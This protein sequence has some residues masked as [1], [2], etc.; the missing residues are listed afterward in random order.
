MGIEIRKDCKRAVA[1]VKCI[2][3]YHRLSST[4]KCT[5]TD[6]MDVKSDENDESDDQ[7]DSDFNPVTQ[8]YI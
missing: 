1:C 5:N 6:V 3:K 4:K 7:N 8:M 2:Q